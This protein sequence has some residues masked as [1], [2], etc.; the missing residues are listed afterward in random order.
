MN[1]QKLDLAKQHFL[2]LYPQGFDDPQ[3]EDIRK[4]HKPEKMRDMAQDIFH[5]EAYLNPS[6][7]LEDIQKLVSRSSMVS[8]FEKP[9]FRDFSRGL[10][11]DE[12]EIF[13]KGMNEL[14]H[15]D[16]EM[17]FRIL[18]DILQYYKL[19]KWTLL[20]ICPYYFKPKEEIFIKPTTAKMAIQYFE[21]EDLVYSPKPSFEFYEAYRARIK[22]MMER[23][24]LTDDFAAFGG[25]I[26]ITA[27]DY[28][29]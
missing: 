18:L 9:K 12:K 1:L 23:V 11:S 14:L 2:N 8:V 20:T 27:G 28:G 21:L 29:K 3:M 19:G 13:A 5:K 16:R 6:K 24:K 10:N 15:G 26:M 17:G 22:S 4:K 7:F 25:F